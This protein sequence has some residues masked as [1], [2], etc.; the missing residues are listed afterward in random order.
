[1]VQAQLN[2]VNLTSYNVDIH[3]GPSRLDPGFV[4]P[5][6]GGF[7]SCD[8]IR[9]YNGGNVTIDFIYFKNELY[10]MGSQTNE[11]RVVKNSGDFVKTTIG[12]YTYAVNKSF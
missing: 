9:L 2:I 5:N 3:K 4:L 11:L 1:M 12:S 8:T 10:A 7:G 6:S